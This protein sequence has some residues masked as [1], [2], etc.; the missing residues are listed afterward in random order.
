MDLK[1]CSEGSIHRYLGKG[2]L[3]IRGTA[4]ETSC[5]LPFLE[6]TEIVNSL[7]VTS[8]FSK[9]RSG[10]LECLEDL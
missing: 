6:S 9:E 8:P 10:R 5:Q 2:P 3:V 1:I 4:L 7:S